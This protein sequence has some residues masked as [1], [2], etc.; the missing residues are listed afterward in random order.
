MYD[1][2]QKIPPDAALANAAVARCCDAG[3]AAQR[4]ASARQLSNYDS[5][6]AIHQAYR[7]AMPPLA[8][9]D[10]IRDF[11]A[12]VAHGMLSGVFTS[13]ESSKLLYAAQVA[14]GMAHNRAPKA[15]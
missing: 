9:P 13:S 6:I 4:A 5:N 1:P 8:G 3:S 14:G 12:C 2:S 15:S 10:N 11:V 7:K